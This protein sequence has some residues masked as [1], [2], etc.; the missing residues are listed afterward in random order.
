MD[1]GSQ[2]VA[3]FPA[4]FLSSWII[5]QKQT[6]RKISLLICYL[7]MAVFSG[8]ILITQEWC[9]IL[10]INIIKFFGSAAFYLIF[11]FTAEIYDTM[12]R[13]TGIG[14]QNMICRVSAALMPFVMQAAF[15]LGTFGPFV[16]FFVVSSLSA[17][18]TY[19]LPKDTRSAALDTYF[20]ADQT[21]AELSCQMLEIKHPDTDLKAEQ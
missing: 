14:F 15:C 19:L 13:G 17:L 7:A 20:T 5:E 3:E 8:L 12:L 4:I 9:L 18:G 11:A 10:F 2:A 16:A 1:L 6:G 21:G